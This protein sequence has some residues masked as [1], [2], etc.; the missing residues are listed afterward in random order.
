MLT[1]SGVPSQPREQGVFSA[2]PAAAAAAAAAY[3]V[4]RAECRRRCGQTAPRSNAVAVM[5]FS[6]L[7]KGSRKRS[8]HE[9]TAKAWCLLIIHAEGS[10]FLWAHETRVQHGFGAVASTIL[11]FLPAPALRGARQ[12]RLRPPNPPR[13]TRRCRRGGDSDS[14]LPQATES[15]LKLAEPRRR[16]PPGAYTCPLLSST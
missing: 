7:A 12:R 1:A 11:Q 5:G 6:M 2:A 10:V 16:P 3:V 13:P 14:Q 4:G 8:S 9:A 15:E